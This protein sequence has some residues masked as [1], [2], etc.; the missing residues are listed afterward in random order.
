MSDLGPVVIVG[1][2]LAGLC[3]ALELTRQN[4]PCVVL[5]RSDGVGGRVRT[6]RF[7]TTDG[8]FLLDRGFQ[9]LLSA[10]PEAKRMLD[11]R[12]LDLRAFYPGALVRIGDR[13][14]RVANPWR[15]PLDAAKSFLTPVATSA[16]KP[17]VARLYAQNRLST[18]ETLWKRPETSTDARLRGEGFDPLTIDRFFRTFFGG[19]FFDRELL[20]SSRM[21]DFVF[22][23]FATGETVLPAGGMQQIPDQ[24]A[25]RL[26]PGTIRLGVTVDALLREGGRVRG[27]RLASGEEVRGSGVVIATGGD[28]ASRLVGDPQAL[29]FRGWVSTTTVYFDT[30]GPPPV[31]EPIL[32][33]DGDGT[34]PVNHLAFPSVVA[35]GYAPA[36][37]G[38]AAANCVGERVEND[39]DLEGAIRAQMKRWFTGA[40]PGAQNGVDGWQRLRIVRIREALPDQRVRDGTSALVPSQRNV[41]VGDGLFVAGDHLENASIDGAM[42]CGRRAATAV[43]E[44][45]VARID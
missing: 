22:R 11:F 33:L 14:H 4:R 2:G 15:R 1:A 35:P 41:R 28:V 39:E 21:F 24:L 43:L 45:C 23:M 12:A 27:A 25:G 20:T 37:R 29:G 5:E 26:P 34:G 18:F 19:V 8:D 17:R 10:Y 16:D 30:G 40:R 13:F 44:D 9:V 38:L 3:C 7:T 32:M 31:T 42:S 6:E 36:G